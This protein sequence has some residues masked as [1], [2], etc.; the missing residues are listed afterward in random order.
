M[1][2]GT[3]ITVAGVGSSGFNG[4]ILATDAKL[5]NPVSVTIDL[6]DNVYIADTYNHRIR[7]ILQNGNLTTIVGLGSSGFNGDYLLSN[8]TK[9]NYPQSIAFDSNGNMYI[10][11]KLFFV[12]N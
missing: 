4:D 7:K 3:I 8:E 6:N 2:N 1:T 11:G 10:A 5:N 12:N 9:L